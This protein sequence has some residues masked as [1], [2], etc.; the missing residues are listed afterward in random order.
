MTEIVVTSRFGMDD[1][2][3]L[4]ED[5]ESVG[6]TLETVLARIV[7]TF[8]AAHI[9]LPER[10]FIY[11]GNTVHDCEQLS[12][13]LVQMYLGAPGS[14]AAAPQPCHG[15]R[16]MVLSCQIVRCVP[17]PPSGAKAPSASDLTKYSLRRAKDAYVLLEAG[18]KTC[19][20]W[21]VGAIADVNPTNATGGFQAVV[22]NLTLAIV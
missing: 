22:L 17:T 6:E 4:P 5:V 21:G 14:P 2:N 1:I 20:V 9:D 15:P 19:D 18:I 11:W 12:V 13:S 16:S 8:D 10:Q 7:A 3:V